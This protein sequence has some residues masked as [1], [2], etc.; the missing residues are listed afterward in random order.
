MPDQQAPQP[1]AQL[2]P[3]VSI[4]Q[5]KPG[6]I[7]QLK[8]GRRVRIDVIGQAGTFTFSYGFGSEG[9]SSVGQVAKVFERNEHIVI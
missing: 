9:F 1:T 2:P 7:V 4:D 3:R 8:S 6:T 5:L